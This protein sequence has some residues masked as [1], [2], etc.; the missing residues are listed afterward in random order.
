[1][2][3]MARISV[4]IPEY[5][6]KVME[7][8]IKTGLFKSKSEILRESINIFIEYE[9]KNMVIRENEYNTI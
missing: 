1:M 7:K 5:Y 6:D 3:I 8:L 2:N 4:R 9:L